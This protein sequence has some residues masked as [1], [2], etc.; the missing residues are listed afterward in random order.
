MTSTSAD[1]VTLILDCL[2]HEDTELL[3]QFRLWRHRDGRYVTE[4]ETEL[5]EEATVR[6]ILAVWRAE[7]EQ[8]RELIRLQVEFLA[9][10]DPYSTGGDDLILDIVARLPEAKKKRVAEIHE[11]TGAPFEAWLRDRG[12]R[13]PNRRPGPVQPRRI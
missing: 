5:L 1:R 11:R 4:E 3:G 8:L 7:V 6:E 13:T 2:G 9:I 12:K 10:I